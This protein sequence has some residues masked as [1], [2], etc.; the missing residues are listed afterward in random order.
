MPLEQPDPVVRQRNGRPAYQIASLS[1]DV[2][3]HVDLIVR[4]SDLLPSTLV[5]L[6]L[7]SL[8]DLSTFMEAR[9]L[10]HPLLLDDRGGKLSKSHGAGSLNALREA[11]DDPRKV[12]ALADQLLREVGISG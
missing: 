4:G 10:H 3:F 9:F 8:L 5:Q 12:H 7:A 2:D 6:H 11:G 1:D